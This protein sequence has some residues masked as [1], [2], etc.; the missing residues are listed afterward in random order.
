M[1][2]Q[3]P[4]RFEYW[5]NQTFDDFFPAGNQEILAHL[6]Q[7]VQGDGEPFIFLSG[8]A[9]HGKSHLLHA[10]CEHAFNL[11]IGSFYFDLQLNSTSSGIFD[12]L[13]N[14]ELVCLDNVQAVCGQEEWE[15]A[16]FNFFNRQRENNHRLIIAANARASSLAFNLPDLKTRLNWGLPLKIQPLD[17]ENK[18]N[19]LVHK[20]RQMGVELSPVTA[21]FLLTHY[22]RRLAALWMALDQLD[23]ASLAAKRKLTIPF[24]KETLVL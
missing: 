4:I 18:S 15:T 22:D 6:R 14:I 20:A 13:E 23:L 17:E 16:L 11:N 21:R 10:C 24:L 12:E 9:G 7:T 19:L 2:E 5:G 3:I 8:E 1:P